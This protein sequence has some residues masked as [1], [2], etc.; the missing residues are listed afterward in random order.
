MLGQQQMLTSLGNYFSSE[1]T[2]FLNNPKIKRDII[3]KGLKVV[4]LHFVI[5]E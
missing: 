1:Q 3:Q 5:S 2:Y 4:N